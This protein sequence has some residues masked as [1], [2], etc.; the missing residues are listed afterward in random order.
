MNVCMFRLY[1]CHG[2]SW[3]ESLTYFNLDW[4]F[5]HLGSYSGNISSLQGQP[6]QSMRISNNFQGS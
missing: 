5:I 2:I 4:M 1:S 3:L 6:G